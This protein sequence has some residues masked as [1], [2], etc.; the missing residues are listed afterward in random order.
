MRYRGQPI[1]AIAVILVAWARRS[2]LL[3]ASSSMERANP[4]R[5]RRYQPHFS[6]CY[7]RQADAPL[8]RSRPRDGMRPGV[9]GS[10]AMGPRRPFRT[11]IAA[12]AGIA[13]AP[14]MVLGLFA[15]LRTEVSQRLET[16]RECARL[17]PYPESATDLRATTSGGPFSRSF[18]VQFTAPAADIERW[19]EASPGTRGIA[20]ARPSAGK[21]LYIIEPG[22]GAKSAEVTV[23]DA[24]GLVII[25]VS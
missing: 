20:P 8:P 23:D 22:G 4:P 3:R 1:A 5:A 13:C 15:A 25:S 19:L 18:R 6:R 2:R 16:P 12:C 10:D 11:T 14:L 17:A 21:R 24:A 9:L 7:R